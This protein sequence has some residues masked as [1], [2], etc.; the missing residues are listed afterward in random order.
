V[1]GARRSAI[2]WA[3]PLRHVGDEA[4]TLAA[5]FA[6]AVARP[7]LSLLPVG[8]RL[9]RERAARRRLVRVLLLGAVAW[10]TA[11]AFHTAKLVHA[12]READRGLARLGP[13]LDRAL[14]VRRDLALAQDALATIAAAETERSRTLLLLAD[15]TAALG[16]SAFLVSLRLAEDGTLR[17]AGYAAQAPRVLAELERV[18]WLREAAFDGPAAREL[19]G[20]GADR[21]EWDRFSLVAGV[22]P[23]P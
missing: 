19:L 4:S 22:E 5:A 12:V 21:R 7:R 9:A 13:A 1:R 15:L 6:A 3:K 10:C 17:L 16:D 18:P 20:E 11:G 14:A 2:G 23:A 8:A